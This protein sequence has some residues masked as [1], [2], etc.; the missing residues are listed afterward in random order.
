[1]GLP[2]PSS[3]GILAQFSG[4]PQTF[5]KKLHMPYVPGTVLD[6]GD[7]TTNGGQRH[8]LEAPREV[9]TDGCEQKARV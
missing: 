2:L 3:V 7:G 1:M 8:G 6:T 5:I 9:S 4:T